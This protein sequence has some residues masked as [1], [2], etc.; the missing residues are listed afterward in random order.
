M[1]DKTLVVIELGF[2]LGLRFIFAI[3]RTRNYYPYSKQ[4]DKVFIKNTIILTSI[5][6]MLQKY[7]IFIDCI[8]KEPKALIK[9]WIIAVRTTGVGGLLAPLVSHLWGP[10]NRFL[11]L[12]HR[13]GSNRSL[14]F[15]LLRNSS[16]CPF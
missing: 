15:L 13:G 9:I 10:A 4:H 6:L 8:A 2:G 5:L 16:L 14:F 3:L 11:S 7:E 12:L 1:T